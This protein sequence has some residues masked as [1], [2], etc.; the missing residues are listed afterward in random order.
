MT[1]SKKIIGIVGE[2]ASGKTTATEY[3]K[4]K[5]GAMSFRFSDSLSDVLVRLHLE[6]TRA[7]FQK[8]STV[9][10]QNFSEDLLSKVIAEDVTASDAPIIITEG[11]RRPSDIEYLQ[12]LPGFFLIAIRADEKIRYERLLTRGEKPDDAMKTWEQFVTEGQQESEQKISEIAAT[13][14]VTIDNS[15]SF[16]DLYRQLDKLCK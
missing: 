3:L 2:N 11:V 12:K 10:R 4:Q 8:L 1:N 7:N 6:T 16:D 5:Y 15:G 14:G 9:L 13:A